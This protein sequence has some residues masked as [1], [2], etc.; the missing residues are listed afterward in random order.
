MTLDCF[1][2][3]KNFKPAMT[4]TEDVAGE[5]VTHLSGQRLEPP[6]GGTRFTSRGNYGSTLFDPANDEEFMELNICDA[7]L[8]F[9]AQRGRVAYGRSVVHVHVDYEAFDVD[10]I[11]TLGESAE[12]TGVEIAESNP[13]P[14]PES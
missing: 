12:P 14:N 8:L 11:S 10:R 9:G 7:C 6:Y 4:L 3:A 13:E 2:C 1:V 5:P